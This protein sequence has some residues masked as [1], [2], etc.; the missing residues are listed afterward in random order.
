M[1]PAYPY[2]VPLFFPSSSCLPFCVAYVYWLACIHPTV[3]WCH[4]MEIHG[5]EW[6]ESFCFILHILLQI[7]YVLCSRCKV[8]K[9]VTFPNYNDGEDLSFWASKYCRLVKW[10]YLWV[11]FIQI[12]WFARGFILLFWTASSFS[13]YVI[14]FCFFSQEGSI[15]YICN[16]A[17]YPYRK[18]K[19]LD[20]NQLYFFINE[21]EIN[22]NWKVKGPSF[23]LWL[24]YFGTW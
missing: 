15:K 8:F 13:F 1:Y 12:L 17:Y 18:T 4:F 16:F 3:S 9:C 24:Y 11:G 6:F 14:L 23:L 2:F 10:L 5:T 21:S 22:F 19:L 7:G 20:I